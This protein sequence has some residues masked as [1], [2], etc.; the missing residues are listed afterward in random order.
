MA[1]PVITKKQSRKDHSKARKHVDII[2]TSLCSSF[3]GRTRFSMRMSRTIRTRRSARS[4]LMS[5]LR[6]AVSVASMMTSVQ[7]QRTMTMSRSITQS[8]RGFLVVVQ[9]KPINSTVYNTKH[10]FET[11]VNTSGA[12]TPGPFALA[13]MSLHVQKA[14]IRTTSAMML[15]KMGLLMI[16]LR[17]LSWVSPNASGAAWMKLPVTWTCLR[18]CLS[19]ASEPTGSPTSP[20]SPSLL[21]SPTLRVACMAGKLT[22]SDL[23]HGN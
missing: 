11:T 17:V 18:D 22:G 10:T 3:R 20:E 12:L 23:S 21:F 8:K 14:S 19:E 6:E 16:C 15:A 9:S 1:Q 5:K 4:T 2:T 7:P 13:S